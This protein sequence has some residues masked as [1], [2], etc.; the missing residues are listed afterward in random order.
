VR[1]DGH[2]LGIDFGTSS[3]VAMLAGPDG[4]IRSLLFDT[5]PLLASGVLAA[6][7][8][9]LTGRDAERAAA[10]DPGGYEANPKRRIDD[11]AVWLG[12]REVAVVDLIAAALGRVGAEAQRVAGG[13]PGGVVL[14]HPAAWSHTRLA[15]LRDAAARS[16]LDQVGLLAEPIAAAAYFVTVL[17]GDLRPGRCLAVYDLGAGT[18]DIA[19]V[20]RTAAGEFEVSA[21]AGLAD[22]GGLDL[23]AAVI[24][25]ARE[26]SKR[27]TDAWG[28]LDW[29]QTR[30]DRQA[31][32]T[33]WGNARAAKEQL[34]R[35]ATAD[36]HIPLVDV[37]VH[38]TRDEL[39]E[40]AR[41][42]LDRT[43]ALTLATLRDAGTAREDVATVLL[44][45]GSS[46]MPLVASLLHRALDV[47]PTIIDQPE[48][49]VAEGSLHTVP[50]PAATSA[51]AP[52]RPTGVVGKAAV[53]AP[54]SA[55]TTYPARIVGRTRRVR[56]IAAIA[57]VM[58]LAVAAVI[59][60]VARRP[61]P[62]SGP[63]GG[64]AQSSTPRT[65]PL[66]QPVV[67]S[68]HDNQVFCLAFNPANGGMVA[69]GSADN[70]VRLWD[71]TT[72]QTTAV[73]R[74]HRDTVSGVAF[75]ADG[76]TL[77]TSSF[78][79]TV[80]LWDVAT[81]R[82]TATLEGHRDAI[83]DVAF[84][85]SDG[86]MLAT[87]SNDGTVRLWDVAIGGSS[88]TL[89]GHT[90]LV[91]SLAFSPDGRTLATGGDDQTVRL[92]DVATHQNTATVSDLP[93]TQSLAF[94]PDGT[95]LA[96][97]GEDNIVRMWDTASRRNVATLNGHLRQVQSVAFSPDGR[98]LATGAAEVALWNVATGQTIRPPVVPGGFVFAIAFSPD[99]RTLAAG[100]DDSKVRLWNLTV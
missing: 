14:T 81:A 91:I 19:L 31:R 65:G 48:L 55:G 57:A 52:V 89:T 90:G 34:S 15:T 67:L 86:T 33:L 58:V 29:P 4:R 6:G 79:R 70:T 50:T 97:A 17:G 72:G 12:E 13:R 68:G 53:P 85:P 56:T 23:D 37:D 20:R 46:R 64:A 10:A 43:V 74:G 27:A 42:H 93:G 26:L 69:T 44:V 62:G 18:F 59:V 98:T 54:A 92:W 78:D 76:K 21:A 16:G 25:H 3:T 60:W 88:A 61:D 22:V 66:P 71:V 63:P 24:G 87:V 30:A 77:A 40:V 39:D 5:S 7:S 73:L 82:N 45:G 75:S 96:I 94:S 11:G 47:A 95:T 1:A 49:V 80:R 9:L 32:H 84:N 41:P 51:P 28:R 2:R 83:H 36:L 35:Y 100:G 8:D 38:L 99:G